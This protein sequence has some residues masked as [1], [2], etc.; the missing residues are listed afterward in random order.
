VGLSKK[1]ASVAGNACGNRLRRGVATAGRAEAFFLLDV[2]HVWFVF[3][4]FMRSLR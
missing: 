1:R 2:I 4:V 3:K